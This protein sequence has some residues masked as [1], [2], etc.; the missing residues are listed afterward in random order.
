MG[1]AI[2]SAFAVGILVSSGVWSVASALNIGSVNAPAKDAKCKVGTSPVEP[3]YDPVNHE[4]YVPNELSHN[5]SVVK[6][7]CTLAATIKLPSGSE[8]EAAAFDPQ[9]NYVY[10]TDFGLNQVYVISGTKIIDTLHGFDGPYA[11]VY[12]P[13][14]E[15]VVITNFG[16]ANLTVATGLYDYSSQP[17][18]SGPDAI[19]Y[20][21]SFGLTIVANY[22][23]GN[24]TIYGCG[25]VQ[26]GVSV[27]VGS[28]PDGVAYGADCACD[29]IA[30]FG[31]ANV[32]VWIPSVG[33]V[34]TFTG[35]DAPTSATWSQARLDVYATNY[36]SGTLC[37]VVDGGC[38]DK[39]SI[40][41]GIVGS[42]YDDANGDI[43]VTD[44][45]TGMLYAVST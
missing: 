39:I 31:S 2:V 3:T 41:K 16:S 1:A 40:A 38:K 22:Y 23:S 6:S 13:C 4:I 27:A 25:L 42:A 28:D 9:D 35:F 20:D 14:V 11:L 8:P 7:P 30:N 37:A 5:I 44:I 32:S 15:G 33:L 19:D 12:D 29:A 17:A 21:P 36:G 45:L 10:V 18:G 24:V 34:S 26:P 43:Y